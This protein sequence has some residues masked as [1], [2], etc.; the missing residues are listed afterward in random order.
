MPISP[1][2]LWHQLSASEQAA[3]RAD[4]IAVF[5]EVIHA[6]VRTDHPHPCSPEARRITCANRVHIN[7]STIKKVYDYSTAY[8]SGPKT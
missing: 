4:L 2:Q 7:R 3:I 6:Y 1:H 8:N 5:Q